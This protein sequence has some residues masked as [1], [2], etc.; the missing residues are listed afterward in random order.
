MI[1]QTQVGPQTLSDGSITTARGGKYGEIAVT[2]LQPKY[3][4]QAYRGNVFF[5][6]GQTITF[7][8]Q[9]LTSQTQT[10]LLIS[11]PA[12]SS[13]NLVPLQSECVLTA[14]VANTNTLFQ[15]GAVV[16]PFSTTAITNTTTATI[17]SA[18]GAKSS[19]AGTAA[20]ASAGWGLPVVPVLFKALF[21]AL[22]T[23]TTYIGGPTANSVITDYNGS[24]IIPPGCSFGICGS[25]A[26]TGHVTMTWLEVNI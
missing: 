19:G 8:A 2:E 15:M 13:K 11:N 3:Y 1:L 4:E 6:V 24:I 25:L 18:L 9:A 12:S 14:L 7:S 21:T 17:Y 23:T 10:G 5:S 26:D 22:V 20:T 16:Q